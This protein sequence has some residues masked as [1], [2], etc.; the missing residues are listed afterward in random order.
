MLANSMKSTNATS[1]ETNIY[2]SVCFTKC[3]T[4]GIKMGTVEKAVKTLGNNSA[5]L[6]NDSE[7]RFH[8]VEWGWSSCG[9]P[10]DYIIT[11]F[12]HTAALFCQRSGLVC[13][14][15]VFDYLFTLIHKLLHTSLISI[16]KIV[17]NWSTDAWHKEQHKEEKQI[18]AL[19]Q[20]NP[21][22]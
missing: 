10:Y 21:L 20:C 22:A 11:E 17:Q 3:S 8:L 1:S 9:H 6:S 15:K 16:H 4:N 7:E 19:A 5:I 14:T 2:N 18:S 12:T 13:N